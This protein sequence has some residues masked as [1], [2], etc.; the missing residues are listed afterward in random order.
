MVET[1]VSQIV[2]FT[3]L[4]LI[5]CTRIKPIQEFFKNVDNGV[6]AFDIN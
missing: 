4:I 2:G 5:E 1:F 6:N 3:I